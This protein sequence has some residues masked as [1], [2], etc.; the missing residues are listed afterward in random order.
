M[1]EIPTVIPTSVLLDSIWKQ[2]DFLFEDV[3]CIDQRFPHLG[4]IQFTNTVNDTPRNKGVS[5]MRSDKISSLLVKILASNRSR[6]SNSSPL[7]ES[8][9][10]FIDTSPLGK[11]KEAGNNNNL[12]IF[13][14]LK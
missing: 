14:T 6:H 5:I 7:S 2:N 1:W 12:Y 4:L 11:R 9:P 3:K 8:S 10:S 13:I